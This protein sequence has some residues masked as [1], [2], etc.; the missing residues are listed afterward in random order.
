LSRPFSPRSFKPREPLHRLNGKIRAREVRVLDETKQPLGVMGLDEAL[1]LARSKGLD[2]VEIAPNAEPPV[3]R[4]VDYGKFRYEEAKRTKDA[5]K[6]QAGGRMKEIQIS[7]V[8]DQ[9]DLAVKLAQ[10][11]EFLRDNMKVRVKLRFRGRQK[12]HKDI[13]FEVINRFVRE[14]AAFGNPDVPPKMLGDRDLTVTLSPVARSKR[15]ATPKPNPQSP[16]PP[17]AP[18]APP[19]A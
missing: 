5:H 12:A 9:H 7:P 14:V 13:G 16:P 8:I 10:A 19:S 17:A 1:R 6:A 4:V 2:L 15:P 11:G 3:C 18:S